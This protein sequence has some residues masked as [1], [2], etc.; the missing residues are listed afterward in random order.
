MRAVVQRVSEA[1]VT[2]VERAPTPLENASEETEGKAGTTDESMRVAG[3]IGQGF[4]IL[5]GVH[6]ED[7]QADAHSLA[8]KIAH[9]RVWE[10]EHGKLNR[11]L[12]EVAGSALVVSN[13]TLYADC[14]KG[15]RPSLTEAA[16]GERAYALYQA[17]GTHLTA[18]GVPVQWGEFGA[19]MQVALV[20]DGP[21][22]L[23]LDSRKAF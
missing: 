2:I 5:V 9:L 23:L 15:R 17:F 20:N 14:R 16:S 1:S 19:Q 6:V 18:Q 8:E 11:S 21:I 22:T 13:F 10:D 3:R 4:L 7:A 12:L